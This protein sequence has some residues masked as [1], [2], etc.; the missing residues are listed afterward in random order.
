MD[1][2]RAGRG[3]VY[4]EVRLRPGGRQDALL[5]WE[6]GALKAEVRAPALE[7]RAN[8]ALA[9]LLAEALGVPRSSVEVAKGGKSRSKTV[10]VDGLSAE[11][12]AARL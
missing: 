3:G 9:D 1:G 7:D 2:I 6:N 8:R 4:L 5:G 12:A 10:F 11:Q